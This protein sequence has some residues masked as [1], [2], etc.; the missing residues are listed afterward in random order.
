MEITYSIDFQYK[1]RGEETPIPEG[2]VISTS[3]EETPVMFIPSVGDFV[4]IGGNPDEDNRLSS[5]RGVVVSRYFRYDRQSE[6]E[7]FCHVNIIVEESF[8]NFGNL[9]RD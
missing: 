5:F 3:G 2:S 8:Q 1:R 4:E 7:V 6:H 9:V